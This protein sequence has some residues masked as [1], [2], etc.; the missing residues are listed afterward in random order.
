MALIICT[1]K[2]QKEVS[3]AVLEESLRL[4]RVIYI[5][6]CIYHVS[7]ARNWKMR[8]R[9]RHKNKGMPTATKS[10][11]IDT[12]CLARRFQSWRT[13]GSTTEF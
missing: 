5:V 2:F 12:E 3:D 13:G 4:N 11:K 9:C 7:F 1:D 10:G 6:Y 8:L